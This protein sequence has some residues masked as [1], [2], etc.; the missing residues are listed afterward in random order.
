MDIQI[1]NVF[2]KAKKTR[3]PII[4]KFIYWFMKHYFYCDIHPNDNIHETVKF[5]HNGLGIVINK[6]S[7]IKENVYIQHHVTI[8]SSHTGTPT[9]E[10]GGRNRSVR[11]HN[12][13]HCNW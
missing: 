3:I 8:G 1:E 9:I 13:Q 6:N 5:G 11:N 7:I 2:T 12:W 10:G 4:R